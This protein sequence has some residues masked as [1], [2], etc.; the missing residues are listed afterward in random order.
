[1][2]FEELKQGAIFMYESNLFCKTETVRGTT[3][4]APLESEYHAISLITGHHWVFNGETLVQPYLLSLQTTHN[5]QIR[6]MTLRDT[7][8]EYFTNKI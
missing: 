1:M 8:P 7:N 5:V 3:T 4:V 2:K 6:A